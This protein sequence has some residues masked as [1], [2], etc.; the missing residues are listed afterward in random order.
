M[1]G[2]AGNGALCFAI[3][4]GTALCVMGCPFEEVALLALAAALAVEVAS[5]SV[6][7]VQHH[8]NLRY[9]ACASNSL[10]CSQACTVCRRPVA[11]LK[12]RRCGEVVV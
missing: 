2:K 3:V 1:P 10:S 12:S 9:Q 6:T 5:S 11:D 4:T 8:G 7:H